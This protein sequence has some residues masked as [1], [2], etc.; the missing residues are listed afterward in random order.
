MSYKGKFFKQ[1]RFHDLQALKSH[2]RQRIIWIGK[3]GKSYEEICSLNSPYKNQPDNLAVDTHLN[4]DLKN[5][6]IKIVN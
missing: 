5:K 4:Y 1:I 6:R 3:E 2:N